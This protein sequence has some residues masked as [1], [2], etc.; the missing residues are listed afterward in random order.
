MFLN[1][2]EDYFFEDSNLEVTQ[3]SIAKITD[4]SNKLKDIGYLDKSDNSI[5]KQN[6]DPVNRY[7]ISAKKSEVPKEIDKQVEIFY[8]NAD[9]AIDDMPFWV[10]PFI[11]EVR[12]ECYELVKNQKLKSDTTAIF[13]KAR[14]IDG[15]QDKDILELMHDNNVF[16]EIYQCIKSNCND[17]NTISELMKLTF[18]KD[19]FKGY[20]KS[21]KYDYLLYDK[22][23]E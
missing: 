17:L 6:V 2:K 23:G 3:V 10:K 14:T 8:G 21:G 5:F 19:S 18:V 12:K 20:V 9:K 13:E 11:K 15:N 16:E 7:L 4:N 1:N 22:D